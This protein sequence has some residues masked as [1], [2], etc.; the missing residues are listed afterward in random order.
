MTWT[1]LAE[2]LI[3]QSADW[4]SGEPPDLSGERPPPWLDDDY[5]DPEDPS[6]EDWDYLALAAQAEADGAEDRERRLRLLSNDVGAG[7][8][9][10]RGEH[11]LPGPHAG[12]G[13]HFEQGM[14]L[15]EAAPDP[16]LAVLAGEAAG[17]ARDFPGVND[18][19]LLGVLGARRRLI[20][21]Q[22]WERLMTIA[23][24]IR[25][26][27]AAGCPLEGPG[28]MPRVWLEGAAREISA[29]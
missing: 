28:R 12:P 20:A 4:P 3:P 6:F 13:R 17:P 21:R 14:L 26:R 27:P 1:E 22:D 9:H 24:I 29:A 5:H 25:R 23:E 10:H 8:A 15:D 7:Y 2:C 19:G 18:D 11:S 16:E